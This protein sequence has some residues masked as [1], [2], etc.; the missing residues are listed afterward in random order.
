MAGLEIS[1]IERCWCSIFWFLSRI[2]DLNLRDCAVVNRVS[3]E[4]RK[5]KDW[6]AFCAADI[7]CLSRFF[8]SEFYRRCNLR[9]RYHDCSGNFFAEK[10]LFVGTT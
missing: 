3:L 4:Q 7:D 10:D 9:L 8:F 6:V 5:Q 2:L 1:R